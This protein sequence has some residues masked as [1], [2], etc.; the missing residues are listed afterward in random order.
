MTSSVLKKYQFD[1]RIEISFENRKFENGT[2]K[3]IW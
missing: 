2:Y 3:N 1:A